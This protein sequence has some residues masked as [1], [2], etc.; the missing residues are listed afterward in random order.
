MPPADLL[1]P[2]FVASAIFACVPGPSMFYTAAQTMASGRR[3]GWYSAIGFHLAGFGHIAAAAFGVSILL[4]MI[5]ML[6][7]VMQAVGAAYLIWLGV[8]YLMGR[9]PLI[10][11]GNS[12]P[13]LQATKTL[14]ESIGAMRGIG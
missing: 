5:P 3:A 8:K 13:N 1:I 9:A 2:F 10:Q 14:R 4:Q 6:F 11:P 7:I 12:V